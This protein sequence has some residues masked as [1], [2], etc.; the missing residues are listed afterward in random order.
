MPYAEVKSVRL[1]GLVASVSPSISQ[2]SRLTLINAEIVSSA[3]VEISYREFLGGGKPLICLDV[4]RL[5]EVSKIR[6][7]VHVRE[8]SSLHRRLKRAQAALLMFLS[9]AP[10]GLWR[11][12]IAKHAV[13]T[14]QSLSPLSGIIE[15]AEVSQTDCLML[16]T[17]MRSNMNN[18]P[19]MRRSKAAS[20]AIYLRQSGSISRGGE[21]VASNLPH[22]FA[23]LRLKYVSITPRAKGLVV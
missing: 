3:H 13:G 7:V 23:C 11:K 2:E 15:I 4:M 9:A 21:G 19:A 20:Y 16:T 22:E 1:F 6:C 10:Q 17:H 18:K 12:V 14:R 8:S 5:E